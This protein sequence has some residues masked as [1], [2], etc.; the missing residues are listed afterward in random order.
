MALQLKHIDVEPTLF[1]S[2]TVDVQIQKA[3][4]IW[5]SFLRFIYQFYQSSCRKLKG[6]VFKYNVIDRD[7]R[8]L[9]CA[10][11]I[12]IFGDLIWRISFRKICQPFLALLH[13]HPPTVPHL[14]QYFSLFR[15]PS[16]KVVA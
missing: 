11:K 13:K 6:L 4:P 15:I 3:A 7:T 1:I 9:Q 10:L 2:M 8:A 12:W 14:R 16:V 5:P